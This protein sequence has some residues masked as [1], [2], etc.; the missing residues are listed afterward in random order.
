M[1][2]AGPAGAAYRFQASPSNP[3]PFLADGRAETWKEAKGSPAGDVSRGSQKSQTLS[4]VRQVLSCPG[5]GDRRR[6]L[7]LH[8]LPQPGKPKLSLQEEA[9]ILWEE[10]ATPGASFNSGSIQAGSTRVGWQKERA[11]ARG[12]LS[13][14]LPPRWFSGS[15]SVPLISCAKWEARWTGQ[16]GRAGGRAGWGEEERISRSALCFLLSPGR[17]ASARDL[18]RVT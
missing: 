18:G 14:L 8:G 2:P 7:C 9:G 13:S 4:R 10:E 6:H 12:F 5:W 1:G 16:T 15:C 17:V 11:K 3:G